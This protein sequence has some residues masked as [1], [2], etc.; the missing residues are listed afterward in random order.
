MANN[1]GQLAIDMLAQNERKKRIELR[2]G[3]WLGTVQAYVSKDRL[4]INAN[5][6][7]NPLTRKET[8]S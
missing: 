6:K 5:D 4:A 2:I 3:E 7:S 1:L 8:K